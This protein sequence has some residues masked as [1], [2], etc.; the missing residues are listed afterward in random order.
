MEGRVAK[1][2]THQ[3]IAKLR[4]RPIIL[5]RR[6]HLVLQGR[7]TGAEIDRER[8]V[9]PAFD[10]SDS[11]RTLV[12]DIEQIVLLELVLDA[13]VKIHHVRIPQ[14]RDPEVH[15]ARA[16]VRSQKRGRAIL[17]DIEVDRTRTLADLEHRRRIARIRLLVGR[18]YILVVLAAVG[19]E[20]HVDGVE[21]QATAHHPPL[22]GM[23]GQPKARIE[24]VVIPN[25]EAAARVNN[26]AWP[27]CQGIL[28]G[29]IEV[30][31]QSVLG[32]ERTLV[33]VADTEVERQRRR[34]L[35]VVLEVKAVN[36]GTGK[37]TCQLRREQALADIACEETGERVAGI[38][39]RCA[40][41]LQA[42]GQAGEREQRRPREVG[43]VQTKVQAIVSELECML[44]AY[45]RR[46]VAE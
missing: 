10:Q 15:A 21:A 7:V 33:R 23:P 42:G 25:I 38:G 41:R 14:L 1:V 37:P 45:P 46:V 35:E 9:L 22:H 18:G 20:L 19:R 39:R 11:R 43:R 29:R 17:P 2:R 13:G 5:C 3:H 44:A 12:S 8:I 16:V 32:V 30:A 24:V 40:V 6:E 34:Q 4:E 31:H 26:R 36:R 28:R 27:T